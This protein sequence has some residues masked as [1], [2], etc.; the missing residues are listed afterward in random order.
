MRPSLKFRKRSTPL[1]RLWDRLRQFV[2]AAGGGSEFL[3]DTCLYDYGSACRR[4]ERPNA[5]KC[6]DYKRK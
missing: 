3:C 6:P 1:K 5:R 4:P 2:G